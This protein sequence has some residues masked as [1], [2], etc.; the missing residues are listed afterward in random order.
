MYPQ[1]GFR[2]TT[3]ILREYHVFCIA[4][5]DKE[6]T[7]GKVVESAGAICVGMLMI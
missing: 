2:Q 4:S 3:L 5:I 6:K 1:I 7:K